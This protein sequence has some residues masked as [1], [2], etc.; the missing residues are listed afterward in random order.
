MDLALGC[1]RDKP[2][3][4]P[5]HQ[6]HLKNRKGWQKKANKNDS[7]ADLIGESDQ[8]SAQAAVI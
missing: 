6:I 7:E 8:H 4:L 3:F 2:P 1:M 5:F